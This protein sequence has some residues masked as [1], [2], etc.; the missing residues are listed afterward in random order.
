[1]PPK[2]LVRAGISTLAAGIFLYWSTPI[3]LRFVE[4]YEWDWP[5]AEVVSWLC[6]SFVGAGGLL[7]LRAAFEWLAARETT[8]SNLSIVRG[9]LLRNV[10]PLPRHRSSPLITELPNFGLIYGAVLWVLILL[11]MIV[12]AP[13]HYYGL[14]IDFRAHDSV[15]W[16]KSPWQETLSPADAPWPHLVGQEKR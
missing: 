9:L 7:L 12:D 15:V 5:L 1:M 14:P 4:P 6:L 3:W 10:L 8:G 2:S 16:E 11:F 13:R